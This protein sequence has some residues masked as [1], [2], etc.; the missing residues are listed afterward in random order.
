MNADGDNI[1]TSLLRVPLNAASVIGGA[2]AVIVLDLT[3]PWTFLEVLNRY[4]DLLKKHVESLGL[5]SEQMEELKANG[6]FIFVFLPVLGLSL[7]VLGIRLL[8]C[9]REMHACDPV[10]HC[11][12]S[13]SDPHSAVVFSASYCPQL[14]AK[15][16]D[17]AALSHTV[18]R[19]ST[20]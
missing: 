7:S 8:S 15:A 5:S 9:V 2:V 19:G 3:Q 13:V 12:L 1:S 4:V 10:T 11:A 16:C 18:C 20:Y 6:A 14:G 17:P